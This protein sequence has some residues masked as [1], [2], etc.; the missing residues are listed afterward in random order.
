ML[1]PAGPGPKYEVPKTGLLFVCLYFTLLRKMMIIISS[2][3]LAGA[4]IY[5]V[6]IQH[7]RP[8]GIKQES[9]N[10]DV[11]ASKPLNLLCSIIDIFACRS[12][13][14]RGKGF[15]IDYPFDCAQGMP[16]WR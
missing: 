14:K 5:T 1:N 9:T 7:P 15:V 4:Q 2:V 12:K 3:S 8:L 13:E 11:T 10:D 6:S 16:S